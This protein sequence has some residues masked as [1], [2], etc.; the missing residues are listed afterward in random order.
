MRPAGQLRRG[1]PEHVAA[2]A[3]DVDDLGAE[4]SELGADKRLRHE[5]PGADHAYAFE[6]PE[7]RNNTRRRTFQALDPV[8]DGFPELL[9]PVFAFI[10]R[11]S[12]AMLA[13]PKCASQAL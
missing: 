3:F 10:S 1:K 4:F 8:R 5:L 2:R 7:G 13:S 9:D 11:A 6:R 12:C